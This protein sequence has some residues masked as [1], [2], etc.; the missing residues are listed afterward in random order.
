LVE[1]DDSPLDDVM[2]YTRDT[3]FSLCFTPKEDRPHFTRQDVPQYLIADSVQAE[4]LWPKAKD[5][6][7]AE[8]IKW[9]PIPEVDGDNRQYESRSSLSKTRKTPYTLS[10]DEISATDGA[11][12]LGTSNSG[13][14]RA[15]E[16]HGLN[17]TLRL[18]KDNRE[19]GNRMSKVY[20]RSE[21]EALAKT[22]WRR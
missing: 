9:A 6:K 5:A 8:G 4:A 3:H 22:G 2:E 16:R 15:A 11:L 19:G 13:L 7:W 1:V 18:L 12:I 20:L 21:V 17:V 10:G 14:V